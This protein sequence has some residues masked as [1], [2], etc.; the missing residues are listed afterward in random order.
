M[1]PKR[2]SRGAISL[3]SPDSTLSEAGDA[4]AAAKFLPRFNLVRNR[5]RNEIPRRVRRPRL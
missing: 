4:T 5:Q 1:N 3:Q 2:N